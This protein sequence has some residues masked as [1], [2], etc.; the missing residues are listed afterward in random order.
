MT[1]DKLIL[2]ILRSTGA[3]FIMS[4]DASTPL[5]ICLGPPVH[6][7]HLTRTTQL[8]QPP[9]L[10]PTPHPTPHPT[11][12]S[13]IRHA[14]SKIPRTKPKP[15]SSTS[16]TRSVV[17][18][19]SPKL[20]MVLQRTKPKQGIC[21]RITVRNAGEIGKEPPSLPRPHRTFPI[22]LR[23]TVPDHDPH[24]LGT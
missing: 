5:H 10:T 12:K 21:I 15:R 11:P 13:P 7:N 8:S 2:S 3:I 17:P 14:W 18:P 19:P 24:Q 1:Q 16:A 20:P 23:R 4:A 22:S 6:S 9:P